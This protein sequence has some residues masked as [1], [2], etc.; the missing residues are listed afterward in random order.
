MSN[1]GQ[2]VTAVIGG[3]IGFV[4]GGPTGALYGFEVGLLAGT[5]I[6]P[7]RLPGTFGPRLSD[8]QTTSATVGGAVAFGYGFF[9]V[10]GQVI[11]LGIPNE[12]STTTSQGGKGGP[13]QTSTTYSY[14]QSIAI[15]LCEGPIG[16]VRRIW[17][18]GELVYDGRPKQVGEPDATYSARVTASNLYLTKCVIYVGDDVQLP[19]P[20]MEAD[21]GV[22]NVPGYRGLAYIM[23]PDRMLR[24]DQGQRHPTFKIEVHVP[25]KG[26]DSD[27]IPAD[28]ESILKLICTR[29]GYDPLT[30]IDASD[31][32]DVTIGGYA[33]QSVMGGRDAISPLRSAGFF[34]CVESGTKLKFVSRGKASLRTLTNTDIGAYDDSSSTDPMSAISV[35]EQ[36]DV[37]LPRSIRV[38]Y[39]STDTDYLAG[40][41]LSTARFDTDAVN[42]VD[43]ELAVCISDTQAL[44]IAQVLWND[45]W[46]SRDTYTTS[47]DQS[48][49]DLEPS[50]IIIVP[51]L[52]SNYRMRIDK[53]DDSSQILR[54]LTL[55]SDD[56]GTYVSDAVADPT[57]LPVQSVSALSGTTLVLLDIPALSDTENTPSFW[58]VAYGDATGSRWSGAVIYKSVDGDTFVSKATI[59]GSPPIGHL[60]NDL[61]SGITSTWDDENYIDVVMVKGQFESRTDDALL[62]G[63][64]TVAIGAD[65]RWELVQF[66]T[67]TPMGDSS[68][69]EWTRLTHL[70]RGRRGTE[71]AVGTGLAG[72]I[73]VGLTMGALFR[74]DTQV[75]EIGAHQVYKAVTNGAAYSTGADQDFTPHG[76]ALTPFA[77]VEL[78][79]NFSGS[80]Y[81][82]AWTRRDRLGQELVSGVPTVMSEVTESYE[83]DVYNGMFSGG[84]VLRTIAVTAPTATYT[85]AQITTDF[86]STPAS[87]YVRVYQISATVGRGYPVEGTLS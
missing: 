74:V 33:V 67:A 50:D 46:Q 83:V 54:K 30:Q 6:S 31:V 10:G 42:D 79:G 13:S 20:T 52:G 63:V 68:I 32:S 75:S 70:T 78:K 48:Q 9:A 14:T 47:V 82:F 41:Q 8:G 28:M 2:A 71:W 76:V 39:I 61:G 26:Y 59:S 85:S 24:D 19:D 36:Q 72:D 40:E 23:Y 16:S 18:N 35:T 4:V 56:D 64:N 1:L 69:G 3:V 58:A 84:T 7:T 34:D 60:M 57:T 44:Q 51:M 55:I 17:E 81:V 66:G 21:K 87:F 65:G 45:S 86:G 5:V 62:T 27:N 49:A 29:C 53:I 12:H 15:G 11:Y 37:E 80:D 25:L 22:G 38:S 43:V 77:P 73:V